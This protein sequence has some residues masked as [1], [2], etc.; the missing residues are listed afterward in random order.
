MVA[1]R[2]RSRR[3]R[4]VNVRT[5]G[6]NTVLHHERRKPGKPQCAKCG[7]Y[8]KG[9]IRGTI[10]KVQKASK[11]QRR[12]ERPYGGMFCSRCTRKLIVSKARAMVM[13]DG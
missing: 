7:E 8:L 5:P 3:F 10:S 1:P 9:V 4:R 11:T 12:P 2:F 6:G 13:K